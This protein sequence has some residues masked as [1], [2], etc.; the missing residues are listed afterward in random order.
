MLLAS[1]KLVALFAGAMAATQAAAWLLARGLGLRLER[2][3][4]LGGLAAP[5][6]LLAPWLFGSRLLVPCDALRE[7]VPGA[8]WVEPLDLDHHDLLNDAIFQLLP[9][10]LEVRHAL[11]G[12]RLPFWSDL[13]EGGSSPWANPQAGVLSPIQ[14]AARFFP[15][16][17]HLLAALALKILLAFEGTWLLARRVGRSRAAAWLAAAGF[18]LGGGLIS[19]GLFPLSATVAWAPWLAAGTIGLFRRPRARGVAT[20]ALVTAALLLS[21]QPEVAAI[22]GLFAAVCGLGLRR[23]VTGL[24]RGLAAAAAT[25]LLGFAL[26]APQLLPFLYLV[27][28]SQRARETLAQPLP[29]HYVTAHPL[30]W[31]LPASARFVFAAANPHAFGRPYQDPFVGPMNWAE[32]EAGY[33]GLVAFAGAL[34]ALLAVRDRR[35][36]PFLAFA[37]AALLLAAQ[38]LPLAHLLHAVPALRAPAYARFLAL[39]A[40]AL[41]LAGAFG[42]DRLLAR[43]P[44]G[45]AWAAVALAAAASLAVHADGWAW[46]LWALLALALL[47]GRRSRRWG[48]AALAV[49]L[50]VDLVPWS[51]SLLPAGRPELFYPRTAYL[52][53]LAREVGSGGPW[54]AAGSRQFVYPSLLPV[55][56]IAEPRVHNPLAPMDYQR[57]LAAAFGFNPNR[58]EYFSFFDP[59]HPLLDFL[60]V[61]AVVAAHLHKVPSFPGLERVDGDR[62]RPYFLFRNPRALPRWF[63]PA[64]AETIERGSVERWIAALHDPARVALFR[65][66]VGSWRPDLSGRPQPVRALRATPGHLVLELPAAAGESLLAT[67]VPFA[68]GWT[69]RA[70]GRALRT[71]TVDGAF[72]G[73]RV[74]AGVGPIELRF[75]PPGLLAGCVAC[76]LAAA[77]VA[78][79]F[80]RHRV[81]GRA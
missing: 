1:W 38:P 22:A 58:D 20:C 72:L 35:V 19:W 37:V 8:P 60:G 32:G 54:R 12:R 56:G 50:L 68:R 10:E 63:V 24:P 71:V 42:V 11:A 34:V 33:T 16:Q 53:E 5:L 26:A 48:A 41:C 61:R 77:V 66:E 55:Y 13:L 45:W 25:A 9:W 30:S 49:A 28:G 14:V 74:P 18:A 7:Q 3:A 47:A 51:Q 64:G 36:R 59:R 73:V 4:V 65:D 6:V 27:P 70:A 79:L 31:F 57:V 44:G 75:L 29:P 78:V 23:R 39:G 80:L 76:L 17:H 46:G 62:F 40:L 67:S 69:A 2:R 81:R 21:G 15:L 43:R 52:D